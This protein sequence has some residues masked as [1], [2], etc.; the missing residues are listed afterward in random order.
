VTFDFAAAYDELNADD[1]DYRFYAGVAAEVGA[2]RVLDLGCGTG[3]LARLLASAG[4]RVVGIDPDPA[5]LEVARAADTGGLVD[6]R[7]GDSAA[8]DPGWADLAVMSGHVAQ[9]FV[10]DDA[11]ATVL[12]DLWTALAEGGVLAFESR[13][14]G[15]RGW[16]RWNREQTLQTVQTDDGQID[17]WHETVDVDLP[18]ETYRTLTV[19]RRT[20]ERT[21]SSE[22]QAFRDESTLRRSLAAVGFDVRDLYGDWQHGPVSRESR[23][24]VVIARKEEVRGTRAAPE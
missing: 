6:W 13:N 18:R 19:H 9:L 15:A 17:L 7:E 23:E 5:M 10:E 2:E 4:R 14:P 11:W 24:L 8:A 12:G 20:A 3:V 21:E 1:H 16:E 22:T